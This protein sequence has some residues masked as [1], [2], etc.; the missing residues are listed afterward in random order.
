MRLFVAVDP[1]AAE[2][3]RLV[4]WLASAN[5]ETA[6]LR[7]TPSDQ[8]HLT[9][10]FYGETPAAVVP[11][12]A[13]RLARAAQRSPE[14]S[15]QLAGTGSFPADPARARVLWVGVDGDTAALSRL[16][17]RTSA[18]GRRA[19][20]DIEVRR[21]RAHVTIARPRHGAIDLTDTLAA[22]PPYTGQPWRATTIRLVRS[23]L[24]P[25]VRHELLEE[26]PLG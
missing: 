17:D 20:L 15:L 18:A 4:D 7:L 25:P 23:H 3:V 22:L 14:M 11:E 19:G 10:S 2:R 13:E 6:R 5:L 12:L 8:W 1:P 16:A 26:F 21:Y 9:L 24:G